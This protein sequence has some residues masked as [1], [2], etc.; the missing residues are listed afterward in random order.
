MKIARIDPELIQKY[1]RPGPRYTSYPTALQFTEEFS[2][3]A[4]T[5]EISSEASSQLSLYFHL[6]FCEKQCWFCGCNT[7]ISRSR[8]KADR[9]L[10]FLERELDIY[11]QVDTL[12]R[13]VAQM[14]FGGGTPNFLSVEQI[15]RLGRIIHARFQFASDAECSVELAP[16]HLH[17]EQVEAFAAMG[18]KRAS[19]GVQDCQPDVQKA[20][21][22]IQPH[23]LNHQAMNWLR[24]NGFE[25]VNIDL[26]YGLP[27]QTPASFSD[28]LDQALE[29]N[30]DRLAI[31]NYA[32][33]PWLKPAQKMLEKHPRPDPEQRL[34]I[35]Q[36]LIDKLENAG[37]AYIG[38]DHFARKSDE[39]VKAQD[40]GTLQ[41]NFQGYS[42]RAGCDIAAFGISSISQTA[43]SYRQNV[44]SLRE[45]EAAIEAGTLPIERGL[46]LSEDDVLRREV[47][48]K[49]MCHGKL[50][51]SPIE[52]KYKISFC[53][54]FSDA[55]IKLS[56]MSEE[57]LVSISDTSLEVTPKGW[58]L[59]RNIAMP[60]DAYLESKEKTYSKTV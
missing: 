14:H 39:L 20:I 60:F 35:L 54:Y 22:R 57:G 26:I 43:K 8:E 53:T 36:N 44:K 38:M 34:E 30:P 10:D 18:L 49:I 42:T 58:Q 31:F 33:V 50:D 11:L 59:I 40:A 13:P 45:Y 12:K 19:F 32:H 24:G 37:Y 7:I 9:Y 1:A 17:E 46:I 6:P 29:L 48:N 52:A 56:P 41:R 28:T 5:S 16:A 55:L 2:P 51:F 3:S 25:S 21:N 27:L 23:E 15:E 4:L 47:I